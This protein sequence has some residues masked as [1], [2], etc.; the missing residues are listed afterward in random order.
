LVGAP[1]PLPGAI[2]VDATPGEPVEPPLDVVDA[3]I[4]EVESRSGV[5]VAGGHVGDAEGVLALGRRLGWPVFADPRSGCRVPDEGV[6]AHFDALLRVDSVAA[7]VPDVVLRLGSLPASKVLGQWLG[8]LDARQ[9]AIDA[10]GWTYAPE[11]RLDVCHRGLPGDVA[12]Q[13]AERLSTPAADA[14]W[15]P[16]WAS[17]DKAAGDAIVESLA[18]QDELTDPAIARAVMGALS[19]A[20][21][22]VVSSSMPVRDVEW[23]AAPR[24]GVRV[25]ANRGANGIDGV[26]STAVGVALAGAKTTLLIGDLAFLHDVNGL[27][28]A[29]DRSI[30]LTVVVVDNGGGAIFSFLP[31]AEQLSADRYE[32]L[33]GTPHG[34]DL[35]EVARAHGVPA[36]SVDTAG[37]L[38]SAVAWGS[39]EDG[40]R[41]VVV[42]TDRATNVAAHAA[43]HGAVADTVS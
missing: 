33:F 9:V 14:A 21:D 11:G 13:V 43:L 27:L 25:L 40:V 42:R 38:S 10:D 36:E 18:K 6:V 15:L 20:S 22:L 35:V 30:D 41:V 16:R 32:R 37:E 26:V 8:G 5:I 34:L 24:A 3:I 2:D 19:D 31:Q 12:R 29:A 4:G 1:G 17:W 28:G 39:G 7:A 23:Y